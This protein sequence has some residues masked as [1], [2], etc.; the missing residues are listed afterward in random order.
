MAALFSRQ[1]NLTGA[2]IQVLTLLTVASLLNTSCSNSMK[3]NENAVGQV[4]IK[5]VC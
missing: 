4:K 5:F 2:I 3:V 1:L